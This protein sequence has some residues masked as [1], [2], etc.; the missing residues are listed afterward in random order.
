M[1]TLVIGVDPGLTT[2]LMALRF[3]NDRLAADPIAV[4][5]HGPAGVLPFVHSLLA[6]PDADARPALIAVEQFVVGGRATRSR[7]PNAGKA[8][9]DLVAALQ[10]LNRL[11]L[12]GEVAVRPAA[13]V[14]PWA[15][16]HRLEAAGLLEAC[17]GM[18]HAR[19]AARHALYAAVRSGIGTDPLSKAAMNR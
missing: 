3:D 4:Q 16:D 10:D 13:T 5:I 7:Y 2:G 18:G 1:S 14:K 6:K 15:T 17:A 9:R 11:P 12:V 8:T 19:D